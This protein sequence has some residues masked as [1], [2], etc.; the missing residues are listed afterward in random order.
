MYL[1]PRLLALWQTKAARDTLWVYLGSFVNNVGLFFA[2]VLIARTVSQSEYGAF[3]LALLVLSAVTDFTDFGLSAGMH[4]FVAYY[5]GN[6]EDG[7]LK[8]LLRT[9]WRWRS[10]MV[11]LTTALG[12][13]LAET[14]ATS[15]FEAPSAAPYI[16]LSFLAI[17]G[18]VFTSF[19][20]TYL[21]ATSQFIRASVLSGLKGVLRVGLVGLVIL[22]GAD[23]L[24]LILSAY[25]VVPWILFAISAHSLPRG[26]RQATLEPALKSELHR[27]LSRFSFWV[28]VWSII[29]I[30][31]S[32]IDQTII[33]RHL[34]LEDV[35]IYSAG[36]QLIVLY[37]YITQS[38]SSVLAPKMGSVQHKSELWPIIRRSYRWIIPT[39]VLLA[40]FIYPSQYV[41]LW[42]F[43][44][45]YAESMRYYVILSYGTLLTLATVPF[46]KMIFIFNRTEFNAVTSSVQL[47]VTLVLNIIL[48]PRYGVMGAAITFV[49]NIAVVQLMSTMIALWLLRTQEL[50]KM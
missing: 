5:A 12:V 46:A 17:G 33:S 1:T 3:S 19:V 28:V 45:E 9:V 42:F 8:Q 34:G 29:V 49:I 14:V 20:V 10:V 38:I 24:E 39:L 18:V 15:I 40:I 26:F 2:N 41:I 32:R 11:L 4:R 25:F 37:T 50:Q 16:R 43:G 31:S 7:K 27:K 22:L 48:I 21:Q 6:G 30:I 47:V 23:S 44:P 35:A 36:M 13:L